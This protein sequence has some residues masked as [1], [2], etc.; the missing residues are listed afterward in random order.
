MVAQEEGLSEVSAL[1]EEEDGSAE[2]KLREVLEELVS[3]CGRYLSLARAAAAASTPGRT[4]LDKER[5]RLCQRE[6]VSPTPYPI[7][8]RKIL[9]NN[10]YRVI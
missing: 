2:R 4:K 8:E 1:L 7:S 6:I 3:A 5:L 10:T 9:Y